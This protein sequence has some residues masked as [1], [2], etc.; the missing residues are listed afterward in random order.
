[1]NLRSYP[2][3]SFT[4]Q[5][6]SK[7]MTNA[8]MHLWRTSS[9]PLQ[10]PKSPFFNTGTCFSFIVPVQH[11]LCMS[12]SQL[13]E[14]HF[15]L[16]FLRFQSR[17]VTQG[18]SNLQPAMRICDRPVCASSWPPGLVLPVPPAGTSHLRLSV[19]LFLSP[20]TQQHMPNSRYLCLLPLEPK[21]R[22]LEEVLIHLMFRQ[23]PITLSVAQGHLGHASAISTFGAHCNVFPHFEIGFLPLHLDSCSLLQMTSHVFHVPKIP[24]SFITI[25]GNLIF[26]SLVIDS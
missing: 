23:Q 11:N 21:E 20:H 18:T 17:L 22:G 7:R 8:F 4:E 5:Q 9:Y 16:E 3:T 1:M 19:F 6:R 14:S 26:F 2:T 13:R 25:K 24:R 12:S 10:L 15:I